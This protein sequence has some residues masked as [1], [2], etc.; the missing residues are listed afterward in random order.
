MRVSTL[1]EVERQLRAQV[2]DGDFKSTPHAIFRASESCPLAAKAQSP[3]ILY[4]AEPALAN[5]GSEVD[6]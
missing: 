3:D 2:V 6:R 4:L 5:Q 1:D